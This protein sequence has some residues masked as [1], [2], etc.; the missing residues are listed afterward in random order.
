MA[1][2]VFYFSGTGNCLKAAKTIA[3]ELENTEIVCMAKS[4]SYSLTK[5]YDTIGFVCP[6]YF[7]GLPKK[8]IE[9]IGNLNFGN[10]NGA[11][12]YA[13]I[14]YGGSAG[15]AMNQIYDLILD[16]HN[17]K[18]NFTKKLKMFSNYVLMYDMSKKIEKITNKSNKKLVP[19]INS[20]KNRTKN[21]ANRLMKVFSFI[22]KDFIKKVSD[23]DK[24]YTVNNNCNGCGICKELC[25]VKNI[26]MTNRPQFNHNCENCIA[27]LQ[28]CPQRAINYK[29]ATQNRGRYTHPEIS[30]K[31]L[32]E[33]NKI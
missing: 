6:T 30:W 13:V 29:N 9:F 26:E 18:I 5:E 12:Y 24:D 10:N 8:V 32:S 22:N 3:N 15:N 2:I 17:V 23:M 33:R 31:E 14:T 20:I 7:W 4:G 19:I 27:C 11:Y 16:K 28:F 25:P 21:K 1:N